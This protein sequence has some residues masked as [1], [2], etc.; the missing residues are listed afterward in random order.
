MGSFF[1]P[2]P[3]APPPVPVYEP[4]ADPEAEAAKARQDMLSRM[5]RGR[6]GT[7]AGSERGFLDP[8]S[9]T[10]AGTGQPGAKRLLGE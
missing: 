1:S 9:G 5:R 10:G 6:A 8:A 3:P 4:P 2:K 7:I